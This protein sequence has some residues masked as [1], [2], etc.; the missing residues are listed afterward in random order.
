MHVMMATRAGTC[1]SIEY[2]I[3]RY[4]FCDRQQIIIF[5][6]YMLHNEMYKAKFI[7][8]YLYQLII[9]VYFT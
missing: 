2:H 3:T 9:T 6:N 8:V 5:F 4:I 7:Y 1:S